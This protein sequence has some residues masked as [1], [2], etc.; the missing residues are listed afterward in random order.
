MSE[1]EKYDSEKIFEYLREV[2]QYP[3]HLSE[4]IPEHI[5]RPDSSCGP[6]IP[7]YI[8]D[9]LRIRVVE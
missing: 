6:K 4:N 2:W 8:L 9:D 3:E 7:D 1:F 5:T